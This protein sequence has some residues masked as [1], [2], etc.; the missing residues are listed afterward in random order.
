MFGQQ[1]AQLQT[2]SVHVVV[3][4]HD[5]HTRPH[6]LNVGPLAEQVL[7]RYTL[8][9]LRGLTI[10]FAVRAAAIVQLRGEPTYR[11]QLQYVQA[12]TVTNTDRE[13]KLG[14]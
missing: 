11:I 7:L 6:L 1:A 13:A 4:G 14:R 3:D 9:L 12:V 2:I 5:L 10:N 8:L